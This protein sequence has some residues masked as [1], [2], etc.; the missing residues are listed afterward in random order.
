MEGFEPPRRPAD[1]SLEDS[2][3]QQ[4]EEV[5]GLADI[6]TIWDDNPPLVGQYIK[7]AREIRPPQP[8]E[9]S[10]F[11]LVAKAVLGGCALAALVKAYRKR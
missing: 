10:N 2:Y 7:R 1:I 6:Q 11:G 9:T 5:E 3:R 4:L 8:V